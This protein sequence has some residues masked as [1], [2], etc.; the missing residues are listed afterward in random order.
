MYSIK[1]IVEETNETKTNKRRLY[2]R[3]KKA[4]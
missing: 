1:V 4:T 3:I 2:R